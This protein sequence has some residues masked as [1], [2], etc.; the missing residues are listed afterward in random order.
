MVG[1]ATF[2]H[3]GCERLDISPSILRAYRTA[4][5]NTP[6]RATE[7]HGFDHRRVVRRHHELNLFAKCGFQII[8]QA[9]VLLNNRRRVFIRQKRNPQRVWIT[10]RRLN[11]RAQA[12]GGKQCRK[13]RY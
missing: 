5:R 10:I 4:G 1:C 11:C 7:P 6:I 13:D 9:L 12:K 8:L 3:A 2:L